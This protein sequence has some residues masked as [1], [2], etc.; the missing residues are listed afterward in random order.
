MSTLVSNNNS[1]S[2]TPVLGFEFMALAQRLAEI[3]S[4]THTHVCSQAYSL[5]P[6]HT[7]AQSA[8][9]LHFACALSRLLLLD[10]AATAFCCCYCRFFALRSLSLQF[11]QIRIHKCGHFLLHFFLHMQVERALCAIMRDSDWEESLCNEDCR[12]LQRRQC[13]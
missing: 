10:A 11:A 2:P 7:Q 4:N 3:L 6:S 5:I 13:K 8:H 9:L 1:S 12:N